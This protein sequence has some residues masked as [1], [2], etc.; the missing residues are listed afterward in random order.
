MQLTGL[1]ISSET[2]LLQ[3][4]LAKNGYSQKPIIVNLL[5]KISRIFKEDG[6]DEHESAKLLMVFLG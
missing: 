3:K 1:W 2:E 6:L 4:G 5:D